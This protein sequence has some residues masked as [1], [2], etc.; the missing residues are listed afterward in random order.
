[1][2][3]TT[4][5]I[6][7]RASTGRG[8]FIQMFLQTIYNFVQFKYVG[9]IMSSRP[10]LILSR[11]LAHYNLWELSISIGSPSGPTLQACPPGISR[12]Y[13]KYGCAPILADVQSW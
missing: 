12:D 8:L 4:T 6:L 11:H 9:N 1:M 2:N 3:M 10:C 5:G 7:E 13:L